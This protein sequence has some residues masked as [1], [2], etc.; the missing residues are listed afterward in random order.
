MQLSPF[1]L[2][3]LVVGSFLAIVGLNILSK[4]RSDDA[5]RTQLSGT[6]AADWLKIRTK[7]V[8][9]ESME[10]VAV[11]GDIDDGEINGGE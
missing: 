9:E 8:A 11:T 6:S 10:P 1:Q 3:S 4:A 5:F 2:G 7:R